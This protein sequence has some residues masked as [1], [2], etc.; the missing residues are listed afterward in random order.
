M[1]G[2]RVNTS[3]QSQ[4]ILLNYSRHKIFLSKPESKKHNSRSLRKP[5]DRRN[6]GSSPSLRRTGGLFASV[7]WTTNKSSVK[8]DGLAVSTIDVVNLLHYKYHGWVFFPMRKHECVC[9]F[10]V[11][12][13]WWYLVLKLANQ[14]AFLSLGIAKC[15]IYS[16]STQS[17]LWLK[18]KTQPNQSKSKQFFEINLVLK[19][20]F[21]TKSS[22]VLASFI[23]VCWWQISQKISISSGCCA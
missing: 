8:I 20:F 23:F 1:L 9:F 14:F 3:S 19:I 16:T 15:N 4:F 7:W 21:R 18:L 10:F 12:P 22:M 17:K 13:F 5:F 2:W 11:F 6:S